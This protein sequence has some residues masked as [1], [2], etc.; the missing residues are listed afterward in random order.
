MVNNSLHGSK[1]LILYLDYA[2]LPALNQLMHFI[3]HFEDKESL[4]LFGLFRF[5]L[6]ESIKNYFPENHI[7]ITQRGNEHINDQLVFNQTLEEIIQ[8]TDALIKL[9]IHLNLT[10]SFIMF[11]DILKIL[12]RYPDKVSFKHLHLYDDGSGNYVKLHQAMLDKNFE[13]ELR[14]ELH[15]I[16]TDKKFKNNTINFYF[17]NEFLPTTYHLLRPDYFKNNSKLNNLW[18]YLSD[19][20]V[21]MT[22]FDHARNWSYSQQFLFLE[23]LNVSL[24]EFNDS[25]NSLLHHSLFIGT[26]TLFINEKALKDEQKSMNEIILNSLHDPLHPQ[27]IPEKLAY[28]KHPADYQNEYLLTQKYSDIKIISNKIPLEVFLIFGM[29]PKKTFGHASSILLSL[30]QERIGKVIFNLGHNIP[31]HQITE[32]KMLANVL[33]ELNIIKPEQI[34]TWKDFKIDGI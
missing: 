23:L 26:T 4:R 19:K 28:K 20:Q 25:L 31:S 12:S 22:Y 34:L 30:P 11:N 9:E 18:E 17:F 3:D 21:K 13:E 32:Q 33:L 16:K 7:Y 5:N 29:M 8:H 6:P 15:L 24:T 10:H 27:Y 2:T 14:S 1:N